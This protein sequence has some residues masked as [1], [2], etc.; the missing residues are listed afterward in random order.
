MSKSHYDY[1]DAQEQQEKLT[2]G[3][4][5]AFSQ[6]GQ[7]NGLVG[8]EDAIGKLAVVPKR[9][10]DKNSDKLIKLFEEYKLPYATV[11][12]HYQNYEAWCLRQEKE[13]NQRKLAAE[14]EALRQTTEQIRQGAAGQIFQVPPQPGVHPGGV[15]G[16]GTGLYPALL[17]PHLAVQEKVLGRRREPFKKE[18]SGRTVGFDYIDF[19][20]LDRPLAFD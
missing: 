3:I 20:Q 14:T 2:K 11:T 12:E 17:A 16:I 18:A 1:S 10:E 15:A 19:S 4:K 8:L 9:W 5:E 7:A 13:E 6:L